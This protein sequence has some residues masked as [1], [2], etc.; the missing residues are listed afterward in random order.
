MRY[1]IKDSLGNILREFIS[2]KAAIHFKAMYN[3]FDWVITK[4]F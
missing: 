4:V 3:R 2:Y 1:I